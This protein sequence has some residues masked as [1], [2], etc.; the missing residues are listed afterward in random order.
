MK[1]LTSIFASVRA[2]IAIILILTLTIDAFN[3]EGDTSGVK[4]AGDYSAVFPLLTVAVFVACQISR[5]TVFYEKQRSRG[6]IMAS[7]EVLCEPGKEGSP[8]VMDYEGHSHEYDGEDYSIEEE[9]KTRIKVHVG[10]TQTSYAPMDY[11]TLSREEIEAS[12]EEKRRQNG[13]GSR[14]PPNSVSGP[15]PSLLPPRHHDRAVKNSHTGEKTKHNHVM[16][17]SLFDE[18][19]IRVPEARNL[20]VFDGF[21]EGQ[22]N[23]VESKGKSHRRTKS[24]PIDVEITDRGRSTW[25]KK[26]ENGGHQRRPSLKRVESFGQVDLEQPSLLDQARKRCASFATAETNQRLKQKVATTPVRKNSH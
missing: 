26:P 18:S 12:F 16:L 23:N 8:L 25:S 11:S 7:P 10:S 5:H 3:P 9:V 21:F 6:D 20:G 13:V 1:G 19:G 17:E 14:S 22:I 2:H 24:E 4:V 15:A